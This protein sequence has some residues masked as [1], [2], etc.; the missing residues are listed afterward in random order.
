MRVSLVALFA[1]ACVTTE[2]QAPAPTPEPPP[3]PLHEVMGEHVSR[4]KAA[5]A[6][7]IDSDLAG[8]KAELAWIA[9]HRVARDTLAPYAGGY[10]EAINGLAQEGAAATDL[11]RA[12]NAVG[13]IAVQCGACHTQ[14]KLGPTL[15]A[16]QPPPGDG[17]KATMRRYEW[18][19][20]RMTDSMVVGDR[21]AWVAGAGLILSEPPRG[22]THVDGRPAPP[23]VDVFVKK[24]SDLGLDG[25]ETT[26]PSQ[27]AALYA[28][29]LAT[30]GACHAATGGGPAAAEA[31]A[32]V[33]TD[34]EAAE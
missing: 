1:A 22:V 19:A 10:A 28:E 9:E 21:A 16:S 33:D 4:V 5:S 14:A 8:A 20:R 34:G 31:R 24:L 30:C 26:Q 7:L 17:I 6:A 11:V 13:N 32:R 27:R 15:A 12:A 2:S 18:A 29:Y 23:Q 3:A 25:L